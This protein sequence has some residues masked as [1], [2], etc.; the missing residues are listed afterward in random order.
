MKKNSKRAWSLFPFILLGLTLVFSCSGEE[1]PIE[2]DQEEPK[3]TTPDIVVIASDDN[4]VY[5]LD[6]NMES[7]VITTSNLTQLHDISVH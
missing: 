5:Q 3:D 6:V 7:E 2:K 4:V 1:D